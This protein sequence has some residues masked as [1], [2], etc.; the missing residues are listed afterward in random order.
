MVT[1]GAVALIAQA[2]GR[3]DFVAA[4][5]VFNQSLSLAGLCVPATLLAGYTLTAPFMQAV[6]ADYAT[7]RAGSD[8]LYWLMPGLAL[9][10]PLAAMTAALRGTGVVKPTMTVQILAVTVNTVL[11]PILIAGWGTHYPLGVAGA[12]LAST[13]AIAVGTLVLSIYFRRLNE[14]LTFQLRELRPRL[15]TWRQILA[16]GLPTGGEYLLLFVVSAIIYR[17]IHDFGPDAQAGF[18]A[19]WR[20]MQALFLPALALAFAVTPVVGQNF[21]ARQPARV[22]QTFNTALILALL[23]MVLLAVLCRMVPDYLLVPFV[24]GR[25]ALEA[26]RTFLQ[27]ACWSF[28]P[29]GI[30]F[31]CCGLF[32]GLGNTW[33]TLL[34]SGLR[35][36]VFAVVAYFL[37]SSPGFAPK[38]LWKASVLTVFLQMLL[39]LLLAGRELRSPRLS[40]QTLHWFATG[41]C[42]PKLRAVP[43]IAAGLPLTT[44]FSKDP[45]VIN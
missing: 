4:D 31:V 21:G 3:K 1:A 18:G 41:Q 10:F 42:E 6:A 19:A 36:L 35:V 2:A 16:I 13:I 11:A 25:Q 45:F 15:A 20:V 33:P 17:A 24:G 14:L 22:R 44:P 30:V 40:E 9:Q 39:A 43:R 7:A 38:L 26:G 37:T 32:N 8:Y 29:S 23:V 34:A 12:G 5:L 28:V 27:V